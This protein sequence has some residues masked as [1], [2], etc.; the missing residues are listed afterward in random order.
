MWRPFEIFI[1]SNSYMFTAADILKLD[2]IDDYFKSILFLDSRK[3]QQTHFTQ[4]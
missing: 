4:I 3:D 1:Q 2:F